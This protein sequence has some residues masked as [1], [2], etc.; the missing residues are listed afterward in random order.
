MQV[1]ARTSLHLDTILVIKRRRELAVD[2]RHQV[3]RA[4][5]SPTPN[6]RRMNGTNMSQTMKET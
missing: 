1:M 6:F 4:N 3:F 2:T 5:H